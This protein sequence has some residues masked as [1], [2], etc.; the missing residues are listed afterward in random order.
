[1]RLSNLLLLFSI[2][3]LSISTKEEADFSIPVLDAKTILGSKENP[4]ARADYENQMLVNP[5]T[6]VIPIGIRDREI[7]FESKLINEEEY[8]IRSNARKTQINWELAGPFNVG[9]R[10]RAAAIDIRDSQVIISGGVSGGIWKTKDGGLSW[11][12]T[13]HPDI[14]NGVS[15]LIQDTRVNKRNIWYAATGERNGN[16][17]RGIGAPYRGNGILKSTDNG[18]SWSFLES[19]QNSSPEVFNN[20]FQY[21]WSMVINNQK[22]TENELFVA[23]YGGILKSTDEGE[24]W[25]VALGNQRFDLTPDTDLNTSADPSYTHIIQNENGQFFASMS[26][27]TS[28]DSQY[29]NA[30]FYFSQD[31]E[32]WHK[33]TPPGFSAIHERTVIGASKSNP[34]KVYFLSYVGNNNNQLWVYNFIRFA[35]GQPIGS[36]T[37]LSENIPAFGGETG[38][39]DAQGGYNMLVCVHPENENIVFL[40]GTNLYRSTDG[41]ESSKNTKWVGGYL[42]GSTNQYPSH[43]AD[44][45]LLM[46]YPDDA[47]KAL[48]CH[49]GG[50]SISTSIIADSVQYRSINNGYLT[51]QFYSI[52]QQQD[53]ATDIITGGMQDNGTYI[54]ESL[55]INPAWVKLVLG[56]GAYTAIAPNKNFVYVGLQE[57]LIFRLSLN[58][59]NEIIGFGRVDPAGAGEESGQGYLFVNPFILD[60]LNANKMYVAGGD[61]IWKNRNLTQ[62]PNGSQNKTDIGWK[63][64]R[65]SRISEGIFTT[66]EKSQDVLY[67]GIFRQIPAIA[68]VTSAS[69]EGAEEVSILTPANFPEQGYISSIV[70]DNENPEFVLVTLSNYEIPSIFLSTDG[71]NTFKNVSG[72]LEENADGSGDGPSVRWVEIAPTQNGNRYYVGTSIGLFSTD[73][74]DGANTIWTKEGENVIGRSVV[75]MMNYRGLDGRMVV[76]THGNGTFRS[77]I[78]DPKATFYNTA[79][80]FR[81]EQNYPNPFTDDTLIE[82]SLPND[83]MVRIDIFDS[84]GQIVRNLLWGYQ[85][86]GANSVE[87]DGKNSYGADVR[88]GI[89]YYHLSYNGKTK[90]KRMISI[91]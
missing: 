10:T 31:G 84:Q 76:A 75:T 47:S 88:N 19:T 7:Q 67:G 40:G 59:T 80:D 36:W 42:N 45:H 14:H 39:F 48:S 60:P 90:T 32:E 41:F 22:S 77:F 43:H 12:R 68:K 91:R 27:F 5:Q 56:D 26:A 89:Y 85:Y 24:S 17:A 33:I 35:A 57:G 21:G 4:N 38:D 62:I 65:D 49:D 73:E 82:F 81:V 71:A 18:A 25:E 20:Q 78:D 74:L 6:G 8:L 53:E 63:E 70:A 87:W 83:G 29:E 37:N 28:T 52:N 58:S 86:A 79:E 9:G 64:L 72:N 34:N 16:S 51:S 44:Q 3:L 46:F 15:F 66:L 69:V 13:T 2:L 23:C 30:G 54:R 55:G 61:V 1:M 50:L 11:E